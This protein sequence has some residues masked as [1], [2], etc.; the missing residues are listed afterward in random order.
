VVISGPL[1]SWNRF[2]EIILFNFGYYEHLIKRT[3]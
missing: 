3:P 1:F 2:K